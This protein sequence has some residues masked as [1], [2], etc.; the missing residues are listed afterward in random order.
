MDLIVS[1]LCG[2]SSFV[3]RRHLNLNLKRVGQL[4]GWLVMNNWDKAS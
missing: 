4:C 1:N 2:L 3:H